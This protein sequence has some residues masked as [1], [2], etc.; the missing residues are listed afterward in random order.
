MP[1]NFQSQYKYSGGQKLPSAY[2]TKAR[3]RTRSVGEHRLC[4]V[5]A[6]SKAVR[7]AEISRIRATFQRLSENKTRHAKNFAA[8]IFL[9][10]PS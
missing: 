5:F 7:A 1:Q 8:N 3:L 9:S 10:A 6:E 2:S 4:V